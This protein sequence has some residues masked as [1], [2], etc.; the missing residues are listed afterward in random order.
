MPIFAPF[1]DNMIGV[2]PVVCPDC[3]LT[4]NR[5][6]LTD[7]QKQFLID[8]TG[9]HQI[10]TEYQHLQ[11][12]DSILRRFPGTRNP[13][14]TSK[15]RKQLY[16]NDDEVAVASIISTADGFHDFLGRSHFEHYG[17][18]SFVYGLVPRRHGC[19][20]PIQTPG[21][22]ASIHAATGAWYRSRPQFASINPRRHRCLA[23]IQTPKSQ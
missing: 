23:P 19:L 4:W 12:L 6:D 9:Y 14:I 8:A 13:L 11:T 18:F 2:V 7:E 1:P 5:D 17:R 3:D 20:V 21:L 10:L 15:L 22:L 16:G